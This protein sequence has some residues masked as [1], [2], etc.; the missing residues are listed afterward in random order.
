MINVIDII[1]KKWSQKVGAIDLKNP[2][3]VA[4]LSR[5]LLEMGMPF[6]DVQESISIPIAFYLSIQ[7]FFFLEMILLLHILLVFLIF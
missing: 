7:A 1:S 4:T 3:H 5:M 6:N 2:K